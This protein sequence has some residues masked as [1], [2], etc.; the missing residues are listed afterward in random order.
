MDPAIYVSLF[1]AICWLALFAVGLFKFRTRGLWFLIGL[2]V[3]KIPPELVPKDG[4]PHQFAATHV[5]FEDCYGHSEVRA[6]KGGVV[7]SGSNKFKN[8]ESE[9]CI[10]Q[11]SPKQLRWLSIPARLCRA[12]TDA[13]R[14]SDSTPQK[15]NR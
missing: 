15:G 5:P 13:A 8:N 2:P 11:S 3:V 9:L 4:V 14:R 12:Q 10:G 6:K 1:L 7:M